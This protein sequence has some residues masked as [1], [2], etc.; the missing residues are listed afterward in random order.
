MD[1]MFS[2]AFAFNQPIDSWNV[3]KVINMGSMFYQ[4]T[5]FNQPIGS[6]NVRNVTN[7]GGM[8]DGASDFKPLLHLWSLGVEEQF[9]LVFPLIL[10]LIHR[11]KINVFL[12]ISLIAAISFILSLIVGGRDISAAF[13]LPHE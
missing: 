10:W 12:S 3:S 1:S 7:L 6:W 11:F 8:F 13:F 2:C 4:A 9:Y 5:A